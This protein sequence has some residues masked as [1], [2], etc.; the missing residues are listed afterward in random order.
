[1]GNIYYHESKL[2]CS[3]NNEDF[4]RYITDLK[5]LFEKAKTLEEAGDL[6]KSKDL[7]E[8]SYGDFSPNVYDVHKEASEIFSGEFSEITKEIVLRYKEIFERL[9]EEDINF[10]TGSNVEVT[11]N[12][13]KLFLT[14]QLRDIDSILS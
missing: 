3:R 14:Q 10:L 6:E 12:R 4:T 1:M 11:K 2:D 7:I 5:T 13:I 8:N 9:S